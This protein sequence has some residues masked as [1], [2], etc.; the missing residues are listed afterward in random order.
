MLKNFLK[1]TRKVKSFLL[2]SV[3]ANVLVLFK[4]FSSS[5]LT[6]LERSPSHSV[7]TGTRRHDAQGWRPSNKADR[8]FLFCLHRLWWWLWLVQVGFN[9]LSSR[10]ANL[11]LFFDWRVLLASDQCVWAAFGRIFSGTPYLTIFGT[12]NFAPK[13]HIWP[14]GPII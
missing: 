1:G 12:P 10:Q 14:I 6:V 9:V 11:F 7:F 3:H 2:K 13:M 8:K 5:A 4:L